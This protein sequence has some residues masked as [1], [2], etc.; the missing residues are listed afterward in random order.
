MSGMLDGKTAVITGGASGIGRQIGRRYAEEGANLVVADLQNEPREGGTPLVEEA[1]SM[2]VSATYVE[3]D[4]TNTAQLQ[5]AVDA[6]DEFGGVDVMVN[7]AGIFRGKEFTA[8]EESEFDQMM[9]VN[10]KGVFFGAQAAAKK[11][12]E[13]GR[14]GSII[15]MSSVAGLTGSAQYTTYCASKGAVRLLSYSLASELGPEGIRVN[16]IHP[17]LI[18]TEMTTEDVPIIGTE[19]GDQYKQSIPLGRWGEPADVADGAL[20][21]ASDLSSYVNGESLVIDG[22][23]TYA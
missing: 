4:V 17:G 19:G 14:E 12:L 7:N 1:E 15:N 23:M 21:L 18:E 11:L 9:D 2:G 5:A 20:F 22:G 3:C 13:D 6:A 8:V 10:V 16:A